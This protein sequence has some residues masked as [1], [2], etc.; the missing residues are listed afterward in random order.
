MSLY[1]IDVILVSLLQ[2]LWAFKHMALLGVKWPGRRHSR[3]A[4]SERTISFVLTS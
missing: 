1:K 4:Q 3:G 2:W